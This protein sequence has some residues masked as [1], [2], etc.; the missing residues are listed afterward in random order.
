MVNWTDSARELE[1][2]RNYKEKEIPIDK[3][4]QISR[5]IGIYYKIAFKK[6]IFSVRVPGGC[7]V[8]PLR[9]SG[10]GI[11]PL[12]YSTVLIDHKKSCVSGPGV[13]AGSGS[14]LNTRV[15]D[16]GKKSCYFKTKMEVK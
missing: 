3:N 9:S 2:T 14:G 11:P 5:Y 16:P 7:V 4:I 8:P 12:D 1:K 6:G 15:S 13:Q 10:G